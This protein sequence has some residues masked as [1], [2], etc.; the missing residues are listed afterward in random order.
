MTARKKPAADAVAMAERSVINA[1]MDLI[2][3]PYLAGHWCEESECLCERFKF[4]FAVA[5]LK[6]A[7]AKGRRR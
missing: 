5:R 1:A 4:Q 3:A 2:D 7:R 6:A